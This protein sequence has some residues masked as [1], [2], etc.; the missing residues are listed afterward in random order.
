MVFQTATRPGCL[1]PIA[2]LRAVAPARSFVGGMSE[3]VALPA[4][5]SK[6]A[7]RL[8]ADKDRSGGLSR[9]RLSQCGEAHSMTWRH[10]QTMG[11]W[12]PASQFMPSSV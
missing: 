1:S 7:G 10:T 4:R 6:L 9:A 8:T 2:H 3:E 5:G 11:D 12:L